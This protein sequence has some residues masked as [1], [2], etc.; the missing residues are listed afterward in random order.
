VGTQELANLQAR[1]E[2]GRQAPLLGERLG[3]LVLLVGRDRPDCDV[4]PTVAILVGVPLCCRE[5]GLSRDCVA[6][7]R[8]NWSSSSKISIC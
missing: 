5:S 4:V 8:L 6:G 2:A 1:G 7:R 3:F